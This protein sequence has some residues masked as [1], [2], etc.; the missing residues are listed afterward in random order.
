MEEKYTTINSKHSDII[1]NEKNKVWTETAE[2]TSSLGVAIRTTNEIKEKWN[3]LKKRGNKC[4]HEPQGKQREVQDL[5]QSPRSWKAL[6]I[7]VR[8]VL[9]LNVWMVLIHV[10][11]YS[12]TVMTRL[13]SMCFNFQ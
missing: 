9:P 1:T 7:C 13:R 11:K 2:K 8:T 12:K 10:F 5:I 3:N 4:I 6:S